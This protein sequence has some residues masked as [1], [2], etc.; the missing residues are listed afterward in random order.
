[1][2]ATTLTTLLPKTAGLPTLGPHLIART[3]I[4]CR[5]H[6]VG[7]FCRESVGNRWNPAS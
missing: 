1:Q 4:I 3:G 5:E 7:P 6:V 2:N